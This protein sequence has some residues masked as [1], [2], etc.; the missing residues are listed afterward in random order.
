MRPLLI[1]G[2]LFVCLSWT[3]GCG[4][5][6]HDFDIEKARNI[7]NGVTTKEQIADMFGKPFKTGIQ[8]GNPIWVYEQSKYKAVGKGTTKSM[9]LEFDSNGV[10]TNH[11]V[12]SN[13]PAL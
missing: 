6:G 4:T 8:N 7:Q 12:T 3:L 1:L 5:V 2:V 9:T 13:E 11:T 10:V